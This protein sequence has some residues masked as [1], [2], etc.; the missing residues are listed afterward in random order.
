MA[1]K[2]SDSG[3][4]LLRAYLEAV[5]LSEEIQ[6]RVWRAAEL[7][8][9]QVRALRRLAYE[10]KPLG[11]LGLELGLA[12]PSVT[13]LA[14]RLEERGL[15]KRNRADEDRRKV[16]VTLTEEGRRLVSAVPP[17]LDG[18]AFRAA[19]DRM[20]SEEHDRIAAALRDF[21]DAV[22]KAEEELAFVEAQR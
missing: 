22:R 19:V 1:T 4:N 7:T 13:R 5:M 6:T 9:S 10:P 11:Q 8:L 18:T 20:S 14:D 3:T 17:L 21:S 15:L 2:S 16:L 12:P